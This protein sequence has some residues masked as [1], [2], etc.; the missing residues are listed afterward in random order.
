MFA[1]LQRLPPPSSKAKYDLRCG[2]DVSVRRP[3]K[4]S[5]REASVFAALAAYRYYINSSHSPRFV[6]S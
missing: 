2:C 4:K 5:G 3:W 1:Q 6:L